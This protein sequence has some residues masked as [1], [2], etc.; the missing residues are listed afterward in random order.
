MKIYVGGRGFYNEDGDAIGAVA[1]VR[2]TRS[3]KHS[4]RKS[5]VPTLKNLADPQ[6]EVKAVILGLE[7][8]LKQYEELVSS[9]ELEVTI[10]SDC[11][12]TVRCMNEWIYKWYDNDWI[13]S[14]GCFVANYQVLRKAFHLNT[15]LRGL[16]KVKYVW[17][18][19]SENPLVD[20]YCKEVVE[21]ME[22]VESYYLYW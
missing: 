19:R 18:L 7:M 16:G 22:Y 12:Y 17:N 10:F 21:F 14:S 15:R 11:K 5:Y 20:K 2:Q 6:L 1:A 9:P 13:D 8:A 3:N 4:Y